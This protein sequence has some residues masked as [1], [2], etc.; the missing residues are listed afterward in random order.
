MGVLLF[1]R[2]VPILRRWYLYNWQLNPNPV[3]RINWRIMFEGRNLVG[4]WRL[5]GKCE[6]TGLCALELSFICTII[7]YNKLL[8]K[9]STT[10]TTSKTSASSCYVV[11][12]LVN[13]IA[14]NQ[15]LEIKGR[16]IIGYIK[17]LSDFTL[18]VLQITLGTQ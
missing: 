2:H 1:V 14:Y 4:L 13:D 11:S 6:L 5:Q 15:E 7:N 3:L 10:F 8:T 9:Q 16:Y 12:W 17:R 18:L